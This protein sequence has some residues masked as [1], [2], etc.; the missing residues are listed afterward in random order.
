MDLHLI[1]DNYSTH[2]HP[3]VKEWI[4]RRKRFRLH[5]I[6]TSSS[7]LSWVERWLGEIT[8]KQIR[9]GVFK[10]VRELMEASQKYVKTNNQNRSR[11]SGPSAAT[12]S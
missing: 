8:R 5:F 1:V 2:Q 11:L 3:K 4:A 10:G 6:P 7:W 9:R 12:K